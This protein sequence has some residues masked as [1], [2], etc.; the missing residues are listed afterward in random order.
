VRV[1]RELFVQQF[2]DLDDLFSVGRNDADVLGFDLWRQKRKI[3]HLQSTSCSFLKRVRK[4]SNVRLTKVFKMK[5]S[6][7]QLRM[8]KISKSLHDLYLLHELLLVGEE[9]FDVLDDDGGL[10]RVEVGRTSSLSAVGPDDAVENERKSGRR[11]V[12]PIQKRS[13]KECTL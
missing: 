12:F 1:F 7:V 5:S 6:K 8:C 13:G 10:L 4:F 11:Q 9:L 3:V 2:L